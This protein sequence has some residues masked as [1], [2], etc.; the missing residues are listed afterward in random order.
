MSALRL[1]ELSRLSSR[2]PLDLVHDQAKRRG[3]QTLVLLSCDRRHWELPSSC[4]LHSLGH[5]AGLRCHLK[6][7]FTVSHATF[8]LEEDANRVI[9]SLGDI[10]H[11]CSC[12]R[13]LFFRSLAA[14]IAGT[15]YLRG[16]SLRTLESCEDSFCKA[17]SKF[18]LL[19]YFDG[20]DV[21]DVPIRSHRLAMFEPTNPAPHP[22]AP[23]E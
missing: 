13:P 17:R 22:L 6:S 16:R 11:K 1:L 7:S 10:D 19:L 18:L 2:S 8:C 20:G 4:Q 3:A 12:L 9:V 14:D 5:G 21:R 23:R 15:F